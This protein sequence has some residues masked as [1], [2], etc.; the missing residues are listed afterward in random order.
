MRRKDLLSRSEERAL[1]LLE[2]ALL[3]RGYRVYVQIPLRKIIDREAANLPR[4]EWNMLQ[5]GEVDFL[6][7]NRDEGMGIEFAVEF[8]GHPYH[9]SEHVQVRDRIKDLL[10]ARV[11][12][13]LVRIPDEAIG[14]REQI[15]VLEWIVDCFHIFRSEPHR[16]HEAVAVLSD[17]NATFERRGVI[18]PAIALHT[19]NP[20]PAT[21]EIQARLGKR[22]GI[23]SQRTGLPEP[24]DPAVPWE[25]H[26]TTR[27]LR[28]LLKLK[29]LNHI[30]YES[31]DDEEES[32]GPEPPNTFRLGLARQT[33]GNIEWLHVAETPIWWSPEHLAAQA[34]VAYRVGSWMWAVDV[35]LSEY[36]AHAEIERWAHRHLARIDRG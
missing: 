14:E 8:D 25:E 35:A 24:Y 16:I 22:F 26:D 36:L 21:G 34:L 11:G 10:C 23:E 17:Y 12:I 19:I 29:D 3:G 32:E 18:D 27:W 15:T 5:H 33:P 20:F 9:R 2:R 30:D 1:G 13:P 31:E 28:A 6:V 4:D 7:V